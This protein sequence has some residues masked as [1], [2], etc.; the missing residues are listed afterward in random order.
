[1]QFNICQLYPGYDID[2]IG[3]SYIGSPKDNTAMYVS[4]KV[5]YL[6]ENL[7]KCKNCLIFAEEGINIT[8]D[9]GRN[10]CFVFTKTPQLEYARFADMFVKEKYRQDEGRKYTTT[11]EG[12]LLGENVI[13]GANAYI[14]PGCIIGH[15]V[16]L[17]ANARILSG[18]IIKNAVIGED[19]LCNEKA[20][21]GSSSFTMTEDE[22]GNK[23][24]IPTLGG[25]CIGNHVEIGAFDNIC[26]GASGNTIIEDYVKLDALIHVGHE[27]HLCKNTELTA[28]TIVGGFAIMGEGSYSGINS[29]IRNR[30][31]IG[32]HSISGMG[33]TVIS[34]VQKNVVVA[35]NPTKVL[36]A[37]AYD[38]LL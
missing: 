27:A 12:Y 29:C 37:N 25:V 23:F 7:I 26:A 32:N 20:V 4:K 9:F 10:H 28:G 17:G 8:S 30:I 36:R 33:S 38:N 19:F 3:T 24:R 15:D 6:V 5:E 34:S 18:S 35:G 21:I 1:M 13:I 16:I 22:V 2:I 14:E 11:E 31:S